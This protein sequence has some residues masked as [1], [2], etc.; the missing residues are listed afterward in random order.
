[1]TTTLHS[2]SEWEGRVLPSNASGPLPEERQEREAAKDWSGLGFWLKWIL[3]TTLG[4]V[5]G[6]V[7]VGM[8]A[9]FTGSLESVPAR[10]AS[11]GM[12][13]L[14]VLA[15][16]L[17]LRRRMPGAWRWIPVSVVGDLIGLGLALLVQLLLRRSGGEPF[18]PTELV[19][20]SLAGSVPSAL[21]QWLLLRTVARRAW[22]WLLANALWIVP[23]ALLGLTGGTSEVPPGIESAIN[24]AI[25]LGMTNA[26]LGLF[27]S[28]VVGAELV[29]LLKHP[30]HVAS[31]EVDTGAA[32]AP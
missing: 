18:A 17:L 3:V 1:M 27:A 6:G 25:V 7:M 31:T 16:W 15:Q 23:V 32:P 13:F 29:W 12:G 24:A 10:A 9:G 30:R 22:R 20:T 14:T 21:A 11:Y 8:A 5:L 2:P 28:A 4:W 19:L 26:V